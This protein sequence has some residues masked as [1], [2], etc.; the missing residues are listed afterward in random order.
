MDRELEQFHNSNA[1]L[2][3]LIGEL[4]EKLDGMQAQNL[5]Q[6]KR[7]ADQEAS[8]GR[9]QKELYECVQHIQ[10]PPALRAHVTAMYKSNVTVD[11]PRNEM[12]A[13]VIHEYHRHKEYLESSLRY[14]HHKFVADV[15]GHRTENIK[16]MQ[17]NMLL[18]KEINTQ[19]AHN[20]AAKRVLESQVNMLKRFGTSSKHRRAAGVVYS[21]TA[22]VGDRP[23]TSHEEPASI[24]EN[25]KA[26]IASLRALVADLEGRLVSNRPY[27]REILPPMDGVNTVS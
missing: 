3:L 17:D 7:I 25:N 23:E 15:G 20:K 21:S 6:R 27:S 12:D 18:I 24:I 16:V 13:N 14:L 26:K 10:D 4:R 11:L 1:Q 5:D 2:D 9:L 19:R 22:V 8:R